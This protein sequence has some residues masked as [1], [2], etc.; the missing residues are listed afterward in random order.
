MLRWILHKV[1]NGVANYPR[2]AL[3]LVVG[4]VALS[5]FELIPIVEF[6]TD[7]IVILAYLLLLRYV[8]RTRPS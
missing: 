4:Y 7:F 8:R 3:G 5:F 1:A 6:V 2:L